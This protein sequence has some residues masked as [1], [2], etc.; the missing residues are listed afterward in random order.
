MR[1]VKTT[2]AL[3]LAYL[4]VFIFLI[5]GCGGSR[6]ETVGG[7]KIPVPRGLNKSQGQG[8]ELSL[9]GFGGAHL[10]FQGN[11]DPGE[12]VDFYKKEMPSRGWKPGMGIVSRGGM[13]AYTKE[14][15]SV[16]LTV[17]KQDHGTVLTI[18]VGT[19]GH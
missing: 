7:V 8:I 11:M 3:T 5:Q 4:A 10:S 2:I 17:G 14:G 18:T 9:P 15:K 16:L 19:T 1:P 6:E 13:L 12:V